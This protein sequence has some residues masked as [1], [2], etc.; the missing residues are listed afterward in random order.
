MRDFWSSI[1]LRGRAFLAGGATAVLCAVL[2]DEVSL[3][4]A[5][6]LACLL[7]LLAALTLAGHR[8]R[9][10]VQRSVSPKVV[11]AGQPA[12]VRLRLRN[13]SGRRYG[14]LRVEEQLPYALGSRPR[15][16]LIAPRRGWQGTL[17]YQV[18]SE[19]RGHHLIGPL[20]LVDSDPFGMA[21][22][23]HTESEVTPLVVTPRVIELPPIHLDGAW[24]GAG[25]NRPR[26]FA[27]GSP[28]DVT[29]RDYRRGDELRRV[30]WRSTARAGEL[31]VRREE[32]PWQ[33]RATLVLDNRDR[34]HRGIGSASSFETAVIVAASIAEHLSRRGWTVRLL[35]ADAADHTRWHDLAAASTTL[36]EQLAV[37]DL[38]DH[39]VLDPAWLGD[40]GQGGLAVTILGSLHPGD[41][42]WL[43]QL[44][45]HASQALSI[46]L[47]TAAWASPA[48]STA[49][50]A[51]TTVLGL[52]WRAVQVGAGDSLPAAWQ[53]LSSR[54][55][56]G[57]S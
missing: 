56:R 19:L 54:P 4:R 37:V 32:Q 50:S 55:G 31:M 8:Q 25:E 14:V 28:E 51:L 1:T 41:T 26:A 33:S 21:T 27:S 9:L 42:A 18:R 10:Q 7:P 17:D 36:L 3:V 44:R 39:E 46:C 22:R 49:P 16:T 15:F 43:R 20:T 35:T 5:G 38:V 34:S 23:S 24:T 40:T 53:R 47:D 48:R 30:H 11:A 2:V 45:S 12:Q 29:V 52:R 13:P 57:A 6:L